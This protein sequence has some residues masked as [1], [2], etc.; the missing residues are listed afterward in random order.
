MSKENTITKIEYK[1]F[2]QLYQNGKFD[3]LAIADKYMDIDGFTVKPGMMV[4]QARNKGHRDIFFVAF[5]YDFNSRDFVYGWLIFGT[6]HYLNTNMLRVYQFRGFKDAVEESKDLLKRM[7][8]EKACKEADSKAAQGIRLGALNG[9]L[10]LTDV[11]PGDRCNNGGEYG[12]YTSLQSTEHPGVF[13]RWT[14]T[15][16]DFDRCDT[17]GYEG[18]EY[19][20]YTQAE[21]DAAI[22]E[23]EAIK[24][25]GSLYGDNYYDDDDDYDDDDNYYDD[26]DDE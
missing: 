13:W 17:T 18:G 14:W 23:S 6:N 9:E 11:V 20:V 5:G 3:L 4:Y 10:D 7:A 8:F 12:F 26:D 24:A 25:A 22:E 15:T 21:L 1:K 2:R 19:V 16:C